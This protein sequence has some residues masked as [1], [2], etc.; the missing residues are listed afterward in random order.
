MLTEGSVSAGI[1]GGENVQTLAGIG[2]GNEE[3]SDT[4]TGGSIY[5]HELVLGV[6]LRMEV[7]R[8][9]EDGHGL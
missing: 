2:E 9:G 3:G 1:K 7:L 5:R 4:Q 6:G 8:G